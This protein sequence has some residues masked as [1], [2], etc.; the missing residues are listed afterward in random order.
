MV[1]YGHAVAACAKY[2]STRLNLN[3]DESRKE[4]KELTEASDAALQ[5][6]A[7]LQ[8]TYGLKPTPRMTLTG[9]NAAA[10]AGNV[11]AALKLLKQLVDEARIYDTDRHTSRARAAFAQRAPCLRSCCSHSLPN[12]VGLFS[13]SCPR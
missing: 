8:L 10:N 13:Q 12:E 3:L 7:R 1:S 11:M 6:L 2:P 4:A 5:L 9:L